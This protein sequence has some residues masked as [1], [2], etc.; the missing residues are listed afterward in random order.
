MKHPKFLILLLLSIMISCVENDFISDLVEQRLAIS[1][2][3]TEIELNTTHQFEATFFNNIGQPEEV[4]ISWIS[5]DE[6][7]AQISQSGLL[8][9]FEEGNITI[10]VSAILD[11]G[12]V[13]TEDI[14]IIVTS[15]PVIVVPITKSGS[16]VTTSSYLLEGD[17][18]ISEVEN[19]THLILEVLD[20]YR[21]STSLPG[22]YL[23][24]TNNPNSIN[25]ALELG[26]VQVFN[27]EHSYE[28]DNIG[29]NDYTY[30]LYWCKPFSVKVGEGEINQ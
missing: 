27:G 10:S 15:T 8:E 2:P 18:T 3:I 4:P 5:S 14:P 25:G 12:E 30:L 19:S 22:L 7:I 26:P 17:F 23:Y 1:N 13:I 16:I 28:I 29:I 11:D 21:A 24:L 9:T 20:N 6:S